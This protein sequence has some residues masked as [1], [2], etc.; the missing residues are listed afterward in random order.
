MGHYLD[1]IVTLVISAAT[2][3]VTFLFTR[4]KYQ[5]EVSGM[6]AKID[7]DELEATDKAIQ[8]WRSLAEDLR[9]E[10]AQTKR[11]MN[12]QI[13]NLERQILTLQQENRELRHLL[14]NLKS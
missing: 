1:Q 9:E 5:A 4:K 11:Q 8:I 2:G 14:E 6:E 10:L 7:I 3:F 12:Q 13:D